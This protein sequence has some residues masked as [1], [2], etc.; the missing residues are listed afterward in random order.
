MNTALISPRL[1]AKELERCFGRT[2]SGKAVVALSGGADSMCLAFLMAQYRTH[3]PKLDVS[4]VTID[5]GVRADSAAEARAVGAVALRWGMPHHVLRLKYPTDPS[6]IT[7][8]EEV[9]RELRYKAISDYCQEHGVASVLVGHH[10]N[11]QLET[12]LQRLLLNLTWFGLAG[13]RRQTGLPM[14][15]NPDLAHTKVLRPL[16]AFEKPALK[17]TLVALDTP[18]FEDPTNADTQLTQRNLLRY[19]VEEYLPLNLEHRPDLS[20]VS[21]SALQ[22]SANAAAAVARDLAA[23]AAYIQTETKDFALSVAEARVDATVP[24]GVLES[25]R[26]PAIAR[27]LYHLMAPISA[28][29]HFH[30]LYAKI[31]RQALP[32]LLHW[33]QTSKSEQGLPPLVLTYLETRIE[34]HRQGLWVRFVL[35]KQ[36]PQ[37]SRLHREVPVEANCWTLFDNTWWV[38]LS[39]AG[40]MVFYTPKRKAAVHE[41]FPEA[42][43]GPVPVLLDEAGSVLAIP[44][45]KLARDCVVDCRLRRPLDFTEHI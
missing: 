45:H 41:A 35:H 39:S 42:R 3:N 20:V 2:P 7:N 18:W 6:E 25:A 38:R 1:F 27:W 13:L 10:R 44:S 11:D 17:A 36:P 33:L 5:H 29:T 23:E 21:P 40:T 28:A 14:V 12:F 30:W 24:L 34:V 31:E 22:A 15:Q 4:A 43:P 9:A 32:R 37:R 26:L 19:M 16:L 8:F